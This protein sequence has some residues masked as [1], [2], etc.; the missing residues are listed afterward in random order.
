MQNSDL[1][2]VEDCLKG[3]ALISETEDLQIMENILNT[4]LIEDILSKDKYQKNIT[5]T[6]NCL[7]IIG[8]ITH[9][10]EAVNY[11]MNLNICD[12]LNKYLYSDFSHFR[13]QTLWVY[14]NLISESDE[15]RNYFIKNKIYEKIFVLIKDTVYDVL[16]ELNYIIYIL[17]S[18][19]NENNLEYLL[20]D[21]QIFDYV[22]KILRD[23]KEPNI[24][25]QLL[26]GMWYGF[27]YLKKYNEEVLHELE[28]LGI[29]ALLTKIE[30][31]KSPDLSALSQEIME[32]FFDNCL[33]DFTDVN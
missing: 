23:I 6:Y 3:I 30:M 22:F 24:L 8:N 2:I 11:L 29:V 17:L 10:A 4:N 5:D 26:V 1:K 33:K 12:Y 31:I 25:M 21:L 7:I 19:F 28:K 18:T 16:K 9:L 14:S 13:R 27:N 15:M 32:K 20:E